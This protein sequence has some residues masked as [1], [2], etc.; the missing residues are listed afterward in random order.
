MHAEC[1]GCIRDISQME[2]PILAQYFGI[3][4]YRKIRGGVGLSFIGA[5][6][7][8]I[9]HHW[10]KQ[11]NLSWGHRMNAGGGSPYGGNK[12]SRGNATMVAG[13]VSTVQIGAA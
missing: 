7:G 9:S 11:K 13:A 3:N 5:S 8:R 12:E 10:G 4:L 1:N 6:E 2:R